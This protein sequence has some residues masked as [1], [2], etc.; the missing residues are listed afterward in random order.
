MSK[1]NRSIGNWVHARFEK[2]LS[3]GERNF[4]VASASIAIDAVLT[5]YQ[6]GA[7]LDE[8]DGVSL[9]F[10]DWRFNLRKSN[11][12]PLVRLNIET[13]GGADSIEARVDMISERLLG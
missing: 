8:L 7:S 12:E 3:S 4:I 10:S 6:D 5:E 9:T 1:S 13:S 2:F 11:T